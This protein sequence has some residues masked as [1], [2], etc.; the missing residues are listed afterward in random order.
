MIQYVSKRL[1]SCCCGAVGVMAC[2]PEV[3]RVVGRGRT[4]AELVVT[5]DGPQDTLV[6]KLKV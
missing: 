1:A 3:V 2:D 5:A 6:S 4:E